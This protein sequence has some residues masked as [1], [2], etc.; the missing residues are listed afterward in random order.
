MTK[1]GISSFLIVYF[2]VYSKFMLI[3]S[4][5]LQ[6]YIN[7]GNKKHIEFNLLLKECVELPIVFPGILDFSVIIQYISNS[8][9]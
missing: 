3:D 1:L 9:I 6:K 2:S 4:K 5:W 7:E 8:R